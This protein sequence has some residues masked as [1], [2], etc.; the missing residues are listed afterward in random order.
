MKLET[1]KEYLKYDLETGIFTWLKSPHPRIKEGD[2]AGSED[3]NGYI[4][5]R[6]NKKQY[7]AHRLAW[8]YITKSLPKDQIDHIN[9]IRDDNRFSNLREVSHLDNGKNQS[10]SKLNTSGHTGV[11]WDKINQK[12]VA[13]ITVNK[14]RVHLGAFVDLEKAIKV[15]K[16][17]EDKYKFHE[18]HGGSL[19]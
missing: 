5:I 8:F 6:L 13:K 17:A 15:R 14:H 9:H 4:Q 18:N 2:L 16:E 12:W 7:Y 10:K 11:T 1:L 3:K 19:V